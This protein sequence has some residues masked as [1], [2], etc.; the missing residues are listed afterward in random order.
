M[1]RILTNN[2]KVIAIL[3]DTHV[4]PIHGETMDVLLRVRDKI[5]EGSIL[6]THPLSG[7][8]KPNENPYKTVVIEEKH[9]PLQGSALTII[10]NA[11]QMTQDL[12]KT[13]NRYDRA[14]AYDGDF[15]FIDMSLVL[16]VLKPY[17]NDKNIQEVIK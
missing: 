10:E 15:Q 1:V 14:Y 16:D 11:I 7:S 2:P 6:I 13:V 5:H 3:K 9:G 4:L 12:L 17:L 8:V